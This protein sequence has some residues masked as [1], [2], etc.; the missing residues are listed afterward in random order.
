MEKKIINLVG[1]NLIPHQ[2]RSDEIFFKASLE[3]ERFKDNI[4][5]QGIQNPLAV[6]KEKDNKYLIIDGNIRF[7]AGIALGFKSFPC[8]VYPKEHIKE[9]RLGV[10]VLR[11][12]LKPV[13]KSKY[14]AELIKRTK[15][16]ENEIL[17]VT[18]IRKNIYDKIKVLTDLIPELQEFI[19]EKRIDYHAGHALNRLNEKGQIKFLELVKGLDLKKTKIT[20]YVV[21]EIIKNWPENY[22]K[23]RRKLYLP[24]GAKNY[25]VSERKKARKRIKKTL[26]E[27]ADVLK[28]FQDQIKVMRY[29]LLR[30]ISFFV[31]VFKHQKITSYFKERYPKEFLEVKDVLELNHV[32][33]PNK[34]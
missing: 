10:N 20:R 24:K 4:S 7:R 32:S 16:N 12:D 19:N 15:K 6:C 13:Q 34:Y 27:K 1:D 25:A 22:F 17:R 9:I 28:R 14:L 8:I 5:V 26:E 21:R 23:D 31:N 18:G 3:F 11:E 30:Y 29:D 2:L 33:I